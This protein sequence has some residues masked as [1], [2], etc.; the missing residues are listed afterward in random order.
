[1]ELRDLM[2]DE[3]VKLVQI[4]AESGHEGPMADAVEAKLVEL[5]LEVGQ[6]D[7]GNVIGRLAGACR[8]SVEQIIL[9]AH[10][11]RVVP[12]NGVSPVVEDGAIRSSGDTVLRPDDVAGIIAILA[13]LRLALGRGASHRWGGV[14]RRRGRGLRGSNSADYFKVKAKMR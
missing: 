10:L 9:C 3:F 12:G 5:G 13:G 11:D 7:A 4:D 14:H 8:G 1:M 2:V 6:D